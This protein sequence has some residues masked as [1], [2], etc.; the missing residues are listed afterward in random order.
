MKTGTDKIGVTSQTLESLVERILS[1]VKPVKI[2]LFGSAAREKSKPNSDLDV[3]VIV[4]DG[5][6]RRRTAQKIYREM[7]GFQSPVDIIVAT[8]NDLHE[9]G[10]NF[11]F[12]Y[13]PALREGK[14]IYT[15]NSAR[16]LTGSTFQTNV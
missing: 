4:P 16:K 14:Q 13:Y 1:V 8:E 10:D 11:G 6:P 15:D 7:I 2:V 9:Y 12:V 5:T 3:L